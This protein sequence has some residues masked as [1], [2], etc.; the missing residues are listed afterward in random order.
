MKCKALTEELS[1]IKCELKKTER[2][3]EDKERDVKDKE[4]LADTTSVLQAKKR[5]IDMLEKKGSTS[6]DKKVKS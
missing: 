1:A 6:A 2:Q 4:K 3:L 5:V